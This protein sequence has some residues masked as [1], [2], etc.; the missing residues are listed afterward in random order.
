SRAMAMA[1]GS[2][3]KVKPPMA[4]ARHPRSRSFLRKSRPT[5]GIAAA[6]QVVSFASTYTLLVWP[7]T[8]LN[9]PNRTECRHRN[10][11]RCSR[12]FSEAILLP[13][14]LFNTLRPADL[15]HHGAEFAVWLHLSRY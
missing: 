7:D 11:L 4:A 8:S 3:P 10:A 15:L 14:H 1:I 12:S 5:S 6:R 2:A 9:S 13:C